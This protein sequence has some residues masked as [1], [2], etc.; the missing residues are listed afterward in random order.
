[1]SQPCQNLATCYPNITIP[2][3]Y[4]CACRVGYSGI[5]CEIDIGACR[6]DSSCL[7]GGTCNETSI[8]TSCHCP[9][10]KIGDYCQ[11]ESS[12]C[13]PIR[14][15]NGGVCVSIFGNWSCRCVNPSLYS[16]TFCEIKSSSLQVKEIISRSFASVAIGCISTVVGF[17]L[18]MDFL[19]YC[20]HVDPVAEERD[21][22][23]E[24][25]YEEKK[26]R[27]EKNRRRLG[28]PIHHGPATTVLRFRYIPGEEDS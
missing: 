3:G 13:D 19:K 22:Y 8:L 6:A 15:E 18:L 4:S 27:R 25:E 23:R 21:Y 14:C 17:V 20:C 2:E 28:L 5:N 9:P 11:Y 16:G 26:K 12:A 1:M 24:R 10:G 7:Y